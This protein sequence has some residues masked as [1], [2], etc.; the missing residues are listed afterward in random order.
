ML[1]ADKK[2]LRTESEYI[3]EVTGKS[4]F[5]SYETSLNYI[6][7]TVE[8]IKK[9]TLDADYRVFRAHHPPFNLEENQ[10]LNAFWLVPVDPA[11]EGGKT[12]MDL[13]VDYRIKIFLISHHHSGQILAFPTNEISELPKFD[14]FKAVDKIKQKIYATQEVKDAGQCYYRDPFEIAAKKGQYAWKSKNTCTD[15]SID[16]TFEDNFQKMEAGY[17]WFLVAGNT[18]RGLD[19]VQDHENTRAT[20]LWSRAKGGAF[21]GINIAFTKTGLKATFYEVATRPLKNAKPKTTATLTINHVDDPRSYY[22]IDKHVQFKRKGKP[23]PI[24][25]EHDEVEQKTSRMKRK[26]AK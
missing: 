10:E 16:F 21:G 6:K 20:M 11:H 25:A 17:M 3:K 9:C 8:A 15:K 24:V 26:L 12:F 14:A 23:S 1:D 7:S 5:P 22:A 13:F 2:R 19:K 4:S 18:G